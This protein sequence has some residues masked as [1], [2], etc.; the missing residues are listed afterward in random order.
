MELNA[1]C[2]YT[3]KCPRAKSDKYFGVLRIQTHY[4]TER[5]LFLRMLDSQDVD[6]KQC[7][8][9]KNVKAFQSFSGTPCCER[10]VKWR[11]GSLRA[12]T[13]IP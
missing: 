6:H 11:K 8:K 12:L 3:H 13:V 1:H 10:K 7:P 4:V 5:K 9:I 2:V